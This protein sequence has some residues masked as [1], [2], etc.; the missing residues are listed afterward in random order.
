[1][2]IKIAE[3]VI[4]SRLLIVMLPLIITVMSFFVLPSLYIQ[5]SLDE[6][7]PRS[8]PF[9]ATH[10][11]LEKIF[12]GLNQI[13]IFIKV[14]EGDIFRR[15]VLAKVFTLTESLY[16]TEGVNISRI[17]GIAA[18][19][20]R[21]VLPDARGFN[22]ARLMPRIPETDPEIRELKT[23]IKRNPLIYGPLVAEDF[24]STLIQADFF[25][26]V[27]S[28][29]IFSKIRETA[30]RLE[31]SDIEMYY[32]GR[33][34]LE[35]WLD[36]Y[37][38][39]MLYLFGASVIAL[40]T[41]LYALFRSIRA[42]LLPLASA[43]MAALW[44]LICLPL[45][46]F[47]LNPAT[48]LVPFLVFALG[49]CHSIQFLKR[50]FEQVR[51][52]KS[53]MSTSVQVLASLAAPAS[54]S[55][56]TD[57]IGFLSLLCIPIDIIRAMAAA[58]GIGVLSLFITTVL[59]IPACLSYMPVPPTDEIAAQ[60]KTSLL[61][62]LLLR[63][64]GWAIHRRKTIMAVFSAAGICCAGGISMLEVGDN[65]PGSP[66]L[67][68]DSHYN[69]SEQLINSKFSG[70]DPYYILVR[71][72]TDEAIISAE[73]L[74]EMEALENH[75]LD[76]MPEAGRAQSL[77]EYIKGFN[78]VFNGFESGLFRIPES[79]AT[80]GEYLFLY[81]IAGYPGDFDF[82]CD[83]DF[84]NANIKID[85]KDHK[86]GTIAKALDAT[87]GWIAAHHKSAR[88]D[89]LFPGG[90]VGIHAAVNDT[91]RRSIPVTLALVT[92]MVFVL[93]WLFTKSLR[94]CLLLMI[95]LFFSLLVT[96]GVMGYLHTP[97]TIETVPLASLGMGLGVDYGI[98]IMSRM[99]SAGSGGG[100][101]QETLLTSGKAVFLAAL[102]VSLSVLL[103]VFSPVKMD[104][105]LGIC[106]AFLLC[107]NM[108]AAVILLPALL[109]RKQ[110]IFSQIARA[111]H[112]TSPNPSLLRRGKVLPITRGES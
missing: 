39:N 73:V 29:A 18:R 62:R 107:I 35:G 23:E 84:R 104:A 43:L 22:V 38:H 60:Q 96:F 87:A 44:G 37:L 81:S 77:V 7:I 8:H 109:V 28:R 50:Y 40:G 61:D 27:P 2:K 13:S 79:D 59:F 70:T 69:R 98:Y 52:Q 89:F 55:L 51:L 6:F 112:P 41:I 30:M 71:G 32:S 103:W 68:P 97:L 11:Q 108:L 12:G 19:K 74:R 26:E 83:R 48:V 105:K 1:M 66:A 86:P 4:R 110:Q 72:K 54:V 14:R 67:Y 5:T 34:I 95:P 63:A 25:P 106:L 64:A 46:G 75:V 94:D 58:A 33:P 15:D 24:S 88:V 85:L 57:G 45:M 49:V 10:Q 100:A 42:V 21:K 82:L 92:G 47:H 93:V 90:I 76:T 3:A 65:Q 56:I 36:F 99:K 78:L 17:N 53:A 31:S 16:F 111:S 9:I 80:I 20:V 91:I 102:S 101:L